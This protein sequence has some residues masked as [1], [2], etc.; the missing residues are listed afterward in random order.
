MTATSGRLG[1][2]CSCQTTR[3]NAANHAPVIVIAS[4]LLMV[5]SDCRERE[6]PKKKY[7][8]VDGGHI[9]RKECSEPGYECHKS[10][11]DRQASPACTQ[12]CRD[13][14]YVCDTGHKADFESC[15]GSR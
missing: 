10:C 2:K 5:G 8:D 4:L 6:K 9:Q 7:E 13:Q 12:C 11:Y 14:R 15:K 3:S 1:A